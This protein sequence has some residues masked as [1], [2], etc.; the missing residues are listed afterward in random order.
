MTSARKITSLR[1]ILAYV[2]P[3]NMKLNDP[4]R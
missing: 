2:G 4:K 1:A 3:H